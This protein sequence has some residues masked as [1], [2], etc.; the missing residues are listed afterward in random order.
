MNEQKEEVL[1]AFPGWLIQYLAAN[2]AVFCFGML[3]WLT[4]E[5]IRPIDQHRRK[6]ESVLFLMLLCVFLTPVGAYL[7]SLFVR[8][9]N[10]LREVK[11]G[12]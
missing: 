7:V 3:F 5:N 6:P 1:M 10:L 2:M 4:A 8:S 12:Q 9:R 11:A